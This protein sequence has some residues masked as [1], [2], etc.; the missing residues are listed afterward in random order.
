[1][2]N[3]MYSNTPLKQH[4]ISQDFYIML[5]RVLYYQGNVIQAITG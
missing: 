2:G 5:M 3:L 4:S 1:M